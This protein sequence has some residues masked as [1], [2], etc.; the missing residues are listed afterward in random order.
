MIHTDMVIRRIPTG[1]GALG[2]RPRVLHF[3]HYSLAMALVFSVFHIES[4]IHNLDSLA[5][6]MG[7]FSHRAK[8]MLRI[9]WK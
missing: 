6:T 8:I 2:G 9:A 5:F 3:S 7:G 4:T 1:A